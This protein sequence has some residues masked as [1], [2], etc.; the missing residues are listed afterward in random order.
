VRVLGRLTE[1]IRSAVNGEDSRSLSSPSEETGVVEEIG[2]GLDNSQEG[3]Y[4]GGTVNPDLDYYEQHYEDYDEYGYDQY[5][6][7]YTSSTAVSVLSSDDSNTGG[8]V[9]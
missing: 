8:A 7:D 3:S 5:G 4:D 9:V 2:E 1:A 6:S